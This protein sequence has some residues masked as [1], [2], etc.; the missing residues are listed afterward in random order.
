[1]LTLSVVSLCVPYVRYD[2]VK[3]RCWLG[4]KLEHYYILSRFLLSR[5]LT[6]TRIPQYKVGGQGTTTN[7][8]DCSLLGAHACFLRLV[9][10]ISTPTGY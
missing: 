10:F 4:D 2:Y 3:V 8:V 7:C 9:P 1:M 5:M 6:V